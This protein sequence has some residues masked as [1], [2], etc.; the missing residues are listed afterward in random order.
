MTDHADA[1]EFLNAIGTL[2]AHARPDVR[3]VTLEAVALARELLEAGHAA[4]VEM[5]RVIRIWLRAHRVELGGD[6]WRA[7]FSERF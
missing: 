4:P 3:A 7:I 1:I 5:L 2:A 6:N